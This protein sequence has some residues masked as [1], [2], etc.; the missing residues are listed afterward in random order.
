MANRAVPG[1]GIPQKR[2]SWLKWLVIIVII[3]AV[4]WYLNS[5][6]Y[7]NIPWF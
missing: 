7:V 4:L 6:G 5:Q 1:I 3:I 2:S